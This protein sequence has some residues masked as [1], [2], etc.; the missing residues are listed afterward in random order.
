MLI[1]VAGDCPIARL[2]SGEVRER[3][4]DD[5]LHVSPIGLTVF[6]FSLPHLEISLGTYDPGERNRL[7]IHRSRHLHAH[8]HWRVLGRARFSD[9]LQRC[10]TYLLPYLDILAELSGSG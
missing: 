1:V 2:G 9:G 7:Q 10:L 8:L 5:V 3:K 4:G 6:H